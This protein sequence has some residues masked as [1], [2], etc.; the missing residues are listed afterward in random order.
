MKGIA[1]QLPDVFTNNKKIM[2]SYIL[3]ANIPARIE[4]SKGKL[5]NITAKEFKARLKLGRP[6]DAKDKIP[7]KKKTQ[8]NQVVAPEEA[9]LIKQANEIVDLSKTCAQKSPKN[10]TPEEVSPKELSPEKE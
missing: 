7:R 6:V 8:E 5:I 2:K 4:V 10:R 9:I 1:N 3:A